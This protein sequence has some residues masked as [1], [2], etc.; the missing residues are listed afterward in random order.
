MSTSERLALPLTINGKL[1]IANRIVNAATAEGLADSGCNPGPLMHDLYRRWARG[2]AG[3]L[4]TG[5]AHVD[6]RYRE[7]TTSLVIDDASDLQAYRGLADAAHHENTPILLQL[8]HPGRQCPAILSREPIA[9]SA[10]RP[11]FRFS[12][13]AS[14]RAANRR[15]IADIVLAFA[16]SAKIAAA[17]GFDGVQIHAAHGY[18]LSS[19]LSPLQNRRVDEYGG[20]LECR[21][22]FLVEAVEAVRCAVPE[23]FVV[24][25]KLNVTDFERGGFEVEEAVEVARMIANAGADC[26]ETSGGTYRNLVTEVQPGAQGAETPPTFADFTGKLSARLSIPVILTGGMRSVSEMERSLADRG[27][28]MIGMARPFCVDPDAA[29]KLLDGRLCDLSVLPSPQFGTRTLLGPQ[30][31]VRRIRRYNAFAELAWYSQQLVRLARG[32]E[33]EPDLSPPAALRQMSKRD[34]QFAKETVP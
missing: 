30:S 19:F 8:N 10:S 21:A 14:S 2:G 7:R 22:R 3:L 23:N 5:N 12:G 31:P 15:E 25:V 4:V 34:A 32:E 27:A 9:P 11:L 18:L 26:I 17:S 6:R 28:A 29:K 1:R 16:R 33:V 24:A 20:A 13:Y